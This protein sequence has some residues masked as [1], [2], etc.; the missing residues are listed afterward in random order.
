M[1]IWKILCFVQMHF[2][3]FPLICHYHSALNLTLILRLLSICFLFSYGIFLRPGRLK[4]L[5]SPLAL[6]S[7][8]S[9]MRSL[10]DVR[11]CPLSSHPSRSGRFLQRCQKLFFHNLQLSWVVAELRSTRYG[12]NTRYKVIFL[13][14][15]PWFS[16]K[17]KKAN[18]PTRDSLRWRIS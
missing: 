9:W 2:S 6:W 1:Q 17:M 8:G 14:G 13:T 11:F 7:C 15:P 3:H 4:M 16:T 18:G 5:C 12:Y 10:T